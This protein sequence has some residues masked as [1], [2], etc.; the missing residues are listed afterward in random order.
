MNKYKAIVLGAVVTLGGFFALSP[1]LNASG[2]SCT[3]QTSVVLCGTNSKAEVLSAYDKN[4]RQAQTIYNYMGVT[5]AEIA[6][7]NFV[8]GTVSRNGNIV[9]GGKV[10]ATGARTAGHNWGSGHARVHIPGTTDAYSYSTSA[11]VVNSREVLVSIV[12]GKFSFAIMNHCG[13]PVT[14]TPVTPPQPPKPVY[15]C[16]ALGAPAKINRNTFTFSAP[17]TT[18]KNGATVKAYNWNFGDGQTVTSPAGKINH[19][20]AKPGTYKITVSV[21]FTVNGSTATVSGASCA[22]TVTVAPEPT[23]P[24]PKPEHCTVPGKEHLPKDS[25]E[26]K[27]D[28]PAIDIT[29]KVNNVEHAKVKVGTL[30]TYQIV[31]KNTGDI[32]LKNAVVTDK[33]PAQVAF[34]KASAGAIKTNVWTYTI[35]ELKVGESK[36]FTITAKYLKYAAGTHKNTVCVDTPTVPGTPEDCDDATTETSEDTKVCDTKTDTVITVPVEDK[37]KPGY[38][39]DLSQCEKVSVC[40]TTTT[41]PSVITVPK[42]D[43]NKPGYE[44]VDSEKCHPAPEVPET[45]EV[46]TTPETPVVPETPKAPETPAELPRTGIADGIASLIGAGS[47]AGVGYAYA[48]SRRLR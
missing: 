17:T 29:K 5:R 26:C 13:N 40:D 11:L 39:T 16:N 2:G 22:T 8:S 46:P 41:P 34:V 7:A 43:Q 36:S 28:K 24:T 27:T 15:A 3:D 20:Y 14:G 32:A 33:A 9:V 6:S 35:P 12:N 1:A 30:F 38:T 44:D 45:P 25:P 19:S 47:L 37:N 23:K 31:V 4:A 42:N 21:T 10:V 48:A 18:A